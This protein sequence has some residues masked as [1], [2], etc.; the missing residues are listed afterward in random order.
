M[1]SFDNQAVAP[2]VFSLAGAGPTLNAWSAAIHRAGG[3]APGLYTHSYYYQTRPNAADAIAAVFGMSVSAFFF[4]VALLYF[5]PTVL[6]YVRHSAHAGLILL[7]NVLLGWTVIGWWI[8]LAFA[9]FSPTRGQV[10]GR[11]NTF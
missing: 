2:L 10:V 5:L 3:L 7:L 6:A 1:I 4:V 8:L 11:I 9:L